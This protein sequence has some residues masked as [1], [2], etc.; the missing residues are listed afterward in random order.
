METRDGDLLEALRRRADL[1]HAK[2]DAAFVRQVARFAGG[3]AGAGEGGGASMADLASFYRLVENPKARLA[4]LRAARAGALE[5]MTRDLPALVIAHDVTQLDYTRHASKAD[6]MLIGEHTTQG[7]E[8]VPCVALDPATGAV[9]GVAHDTVVS[10]AGPDDAGEMD[11]HDDPLFADFS[12]GERDRLRRNHRHQMAV[13]VQAL[14]DRFP[15]RRLVHVADREFEDIFI[16][17]RARRTGADFVVRS[18]GMRNVQVPPCD[19]LPPEAQ[20]ARQDGHAPPPGWVHANLRRLLPH[21]PLRPYKSLPLDARGRVSAPESAVRTAALSIGGCPARLYRPAKRNRRYF[22]PPEPVDLNLVVIRET[23][24]PPGVD[25]LCWVLFTSLP[26]DTPEQL[27]YVGHIYELRWRIE[28][29]FRLLKSGYHVERSRLDNA[30]KVAKLLV[31]L[32]LAATSLLS[33]KDKL[34]LPAQGPLPPEAHRRLTQAMRQPDD[35]RTALEWRVF[36]LI[37]RLG[38]WLGRR[39]DPLGPTVLMR[40]LLQFLAMLNAPPATRALLDE[41]RLHRPLLGSLICV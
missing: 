2:R 13:H 9:R 25:P 31:L 5:E 11:Y 14:A 10:A 3:T 18:L 37:A 26:I 19:W 28:E 39:R 35:P 21:L 32:S 36:G 24:P 1:G 20:T 33:L 38:G 7:Y 4:D 30:E 8:Y 27:A 17:A 34:G 23:D 29:F 16:L 12:S 6:R 41:A 40:G 22:R 15:G